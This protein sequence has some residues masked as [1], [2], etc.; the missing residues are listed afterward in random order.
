MS[1]IVGPADAPEELSTADKGMWVW[2]YN[3]ARDA[4]AA[5]VEKLE[6]E[7][8]EMALIGVRTVADVLALG[9]EIENYRQQLRKEQLY[10]RALHTELEAV[11]K[12]A[13]TVRKQAL[14]DAAQIAEE[15]E[16]GSG[17]ADAIRALKEVQS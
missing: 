6:S 2:G 17:G 7:S 16:E 10:V 12:D 8:N 15:Y 11:R 9:A 4:L 1:K 14:E 13:A 3:E 5:E